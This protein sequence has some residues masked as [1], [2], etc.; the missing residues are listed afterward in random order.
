MSQTNQ[1]CPKLIRSN[2]R[3]PGSTNFQLRHYPFCQVSLP[4]NPHVMHSPIIKIIHSQIIRLLT[5]L[6]SRDDDRSKA[7]ALR[8][9]NIQQGGFK[10]S[11]GG[12]G[13]GGAKNNP[14]GLLKNPANLCNGCVKIICLACKQCFLSVLPIPR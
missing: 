9:V 12:G 11:R 13:R 8:H 14:Q 4:A 2:C 10:T 1:K 5:T 7:V 6:V 3:L